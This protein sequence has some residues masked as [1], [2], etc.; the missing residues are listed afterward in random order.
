MLKHWLNDRTHAYGA[1]DMLS[2]TDFLVSGKVYSTRHVRAVNHLIQGGSL[3]YYEPVLLLLGALLVVLGSSG[4]QATFTA[5]H[6]SSNTTF[7]SQKWLS[8]TVWENT[9]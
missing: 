5:P 9:L 1:S 2:S 8:N 6:M 3:P 4:P 7:P